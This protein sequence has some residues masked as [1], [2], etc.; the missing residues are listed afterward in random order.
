MVN[1]FW[2]SEACWAVIE[3]LIPMD[4]RGVKPGNNFAVISGIIHV[5]RTGCRWRDCPAIFGPHT[6]V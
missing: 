5:L 3:A 1:E 4:R 6:T 2:L